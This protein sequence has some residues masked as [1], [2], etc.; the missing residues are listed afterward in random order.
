MHK[1]LSNLSKEDFESGVVLLI[2]KEINWTSFDVVK[3]IKNLLK[4][5]FSF[6]KIKVG[7]AGT[8]D[9][10]ATG[11]LVVC[12]G[13]S[14]KMI[15]EI[16]NQKKEYT[17]ELTMGATTPSYDLETEIDNRY[18][19]SNIS[20]SDIFSKTK[21]FIGEVFQKPPIFS[22]IKVKGER[23][24]EKARRG[25]K[26]NIKKRKITIYNFKLTEILLPKIHF[27]IECSK[28]TYIRSIA[29]DFGKSLNNGAHLSKLVRTKIG[30]F[31][32]K[33]AKSIIEFQNELNQ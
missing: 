28:G 6:K 27:I 7:H 12:T 33:D 29:H 21:L 31:D 15:S 30:E 24:Y 10:L 18:D 26:I 25:E 1:K 3:K 4:E 22:A 2:N 32:L 23:L 9:P 5:K 20:E 8:L 14:T 17:G 13:K 19:I 11:L 16:Q